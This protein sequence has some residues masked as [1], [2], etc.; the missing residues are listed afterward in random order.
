MERNV[1]DLRDQIHQLINETDEDKLKKVQAYLITLQNDNAD[2][3]ESMSV[4]EKE[5]IY[6]S[7]K[8]LDEGKG[9]TH[10]EVKAKV[11]RLLG[12]K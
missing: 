11:D 5:V 1:A 12:R 9:I 3:W 6:K 8:L 7:K 2:W 10:L 4:Q